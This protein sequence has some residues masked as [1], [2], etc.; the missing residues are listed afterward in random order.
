MLKNALTK[1]RVA[2]ISI[3]FIV[4][5]VYFHPYININ[6]MPARGDES[7]IV[8]S[9]TSDLLGQIALY[10][11]ESRKTL[12]EYGQF[13]FWSPWRLGGTP[14]F[15][16][17]QAVFFYIN[18]PLILFAPTVFAGIKWSILLHFAIAAVAM[19]ALMYYLS[20][21]NLVSFVT[22]FV[23]TFN[24]YMVSRLN[25][26]QTNIIYPY[27]WLPLIFLF[28]F[29]AFEKKEWVA[30]SILVGIFFAFTVLGGGAQIFL[31]I[32][33]MYIYFIILYF[34]INMLN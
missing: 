29:Y 1:E 2:H 26:G 17:P 15:A 11:I 20:K 24:G 22:A 8:D 27:A 31:Y 30:N 18:L 9:H 10:P 19:Y 33:I 7:N 14:T 34:I 3:I 4:I 16:K 13:P 28:T 21:N 6:T 23:Y 32:A 25:W 12:E 5:L